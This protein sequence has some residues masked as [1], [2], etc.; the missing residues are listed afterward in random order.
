[1]KNLYLSWSK[2]N[3]I[4]I[5]Q[6]DFRRVYNKNIYPSTDKPFFYFII[7]D[8]KKYVHRQSLE[9]FYSNGDTYHTDEFNNYCF[10][11]KK[12][13][14]LPITN[15]LITCKSQLLPKLIEV[16]NDFLIFEYVKGQELVAAS[17]TIFYDLKKYH[18][19]LKYTPFYNSVNENIIIT[20]S[21]YKI[22][23]FKQFQE[24]D[25]KPFFL[26]LDLENRTELH[27]E[28]GEDVQNVLSFIEQEYT[29]HNISVIQY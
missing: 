2:T 23:D 12:F 7:Y 9:F 4:R 24:K 15:F 17:R 1:M 19:E 10:L 6:N 14:P 26:Y 5:A 8:N 22:I 3:N 21:G 16:T 13:V 28:H 18:T 27:I 25:D 20:D 29:I 11:T